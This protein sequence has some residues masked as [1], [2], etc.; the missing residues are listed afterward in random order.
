MMIAVKDGLVLLALLI[1]Q[2]LFS[3]D[4]RRPPIVVTITRRSEVIQCPLTH[5]IVPSRG[6]PHVGGQVGLLAYTQS[7]LKQSSIQNRLAN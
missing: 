7:S 3:W 4:R 2:N 6:I 5:S 1:Q